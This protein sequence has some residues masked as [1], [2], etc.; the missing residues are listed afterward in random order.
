V[1]HHQNLRDEGSDQW[2]LRERRVKRGRLGATSTLNVSWELLFCTDEKSGRKLK[3]TVA[4]L[5]ST[6]PPPLGSLTTV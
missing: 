2:N 1:Q 3:S 5:R 6:F 4:G